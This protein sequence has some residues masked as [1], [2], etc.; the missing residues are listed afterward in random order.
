MFSPKVATEEKKLFL[1]TFDILRKGGQNTKIK[2][3]ESLQ[4]FRISCK[5]E[6][7]WKQALFQLKSWK[8]G[9]NLI[10]LYYFYGMISV[11]SRASFCCCASSTP[12]G[13]SEKFL[14]KFTAVLTS[15]DSRYLHLTGI[16]AS[17]LSD[18]SC[19]GHTLHLALLWCPIWW[20]PQ[21]AA[22]AVHQYFPPVILRPV[23]LRSTHH[24]SVA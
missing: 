3:R 17:C 9:N 11:Y 12:V 13:E 23:H 15:W 4:R 6:F 10:F 16:R 8:G 21:D 24:G 20:Y 18:L 22:Q 1:I 14:F 19:L 5:Q 7:G 2:T